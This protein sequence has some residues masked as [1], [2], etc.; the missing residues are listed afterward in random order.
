VSESSGRYPHEYF[1]LDANDKSSWDAYED[2]VLGDDRHFSAPLHLLRRTRFHGYPNFSNSH[3]GDDVVLDEETGIR[4]SWGG[5]WHRGFP[6]DGNPDNR[7]PGLIYKVNS[8]NM[9]GEDF[10]SNPD[11]LTLGCSVTSGIGLAHNFSWPNIVSHVFGK[12]VNNIGTPGESA[13]FMVYAAMDHI[14]KYGFPRSIYFL[15]PPLDRYTG[16]L[17]APEKVSNKRNREWIGGKVTYYAENGYYIDF[18]NKVFSYLS[19]DQNKSIIPLDIVANYNLSMIEV[20]AMLCDAMGIELRLSSWESHT[21]K[22][23]RLIDYPEV[24]PPPLFLMKPSRTW[25][26]IAHEEN[27]RCYANWGYPGEITPIGSR[28]KCCDKKPQSKWQDEM[29]DY[30]LDIKWDRFYPHPGFHMHLHLAELLTGE[31][32]SDSQYGDIS[33]WHEGTKFEPTDLDAVTRPDRK[34]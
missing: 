1:F 27:E 34:I 33:A 23:L 7:L 30:G 17:P 11:V 19:I 8:D 5:E 22:T 10:V 20:L 4:W 29:W 26:D 12:S 32:I 14:R 13:A 24:V 21:F 25:G 15:V 16:P 6:S 28:T 9:H 31:E 3:F 18:N 2:F